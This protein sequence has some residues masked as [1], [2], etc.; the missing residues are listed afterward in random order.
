MKRLG[1]LIGL[2]LPIMIW[3]AAPAPNG[4][5]QTTSTF[6]V[7]SQ[8]TSVW[9]MAESVIVI[10]TDSCDTYYHASATVILDPGQRLYYGL[11]DGGAAVVD[12]HII[13][14]PS[15]VQRSYTFQIGASYVDSLRSTTDANDSIQF[16][17]ATGGNAPADQVII[18]SIRISGTV[19]NFD[20]P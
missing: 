12:T 9:Q 1:F 15:Y 10:K 20:A 17:V 7:D 14:L 5:S 2:L 16:V 11:K 3:A 19:V 13:Q 18:T 4:Q 8:Y 6:T